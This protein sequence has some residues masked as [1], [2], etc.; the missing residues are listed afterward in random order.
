MWD[1]IKTTA[2]ERNSLIIIKFSAEW[3]KPCKRIAPLYESLAETYDK[4][5]IFCTIDVE[6]MPDFAMD[7]GASVLPTFQV[8]SVCVL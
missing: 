3:C 2:K 4:P 8:C 6:E 5:Y 7:C 1:M